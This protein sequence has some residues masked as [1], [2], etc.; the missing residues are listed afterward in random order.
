MNNFYRFPFTDFLFPLPFYYSQPNKLFLPAKETGL[1]G[2]WEN[3]TMA[4]GISHSW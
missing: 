1:A 3:V 2:V 4:E